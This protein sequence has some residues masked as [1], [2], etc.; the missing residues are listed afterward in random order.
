MNSLPLLIAIG[1]SLIIGT[2]IGMYVG[3]L[4]AHRRI[5]RA[6]AEAWL[7]AER[8]YKRAYNLTPR[9]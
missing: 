4:F 5:Q 6:G 3:A 1:C 2:G 9:N 7:A 8:F